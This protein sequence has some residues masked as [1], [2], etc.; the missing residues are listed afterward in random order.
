MLRTASLEGRRSPD[1][2]K[3][4]DDCGVED[5]DRRGGGQDPALLKWGGCRER[6]F[7]RDSPELTSG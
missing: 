7:G 2:N 4:R 5:G 6:R 3:V 1:I